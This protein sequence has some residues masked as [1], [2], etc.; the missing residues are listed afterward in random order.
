MGKIISSLYPFH[1]EVQLHTTDGV[2][3]ILKRIPL[4]KALSKIVANDINI[5][6]KEDKTWSKNDSHEV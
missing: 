4:C 2:K 1:N 3:I 6:F 5:I